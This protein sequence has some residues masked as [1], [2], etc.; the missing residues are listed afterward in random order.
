MTIMSS[1]QKDVWRACDR[2][3]FD[4]NSSPNKNGMKFQVVCD[5]SANSNENNFFNYNWIRETN[6]H[7]GS[8]NKLEE[9]FFR[10]ER[11]HLV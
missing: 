9:S 6:S 3:R 10:C 1:P 8:Q 7:G 11:E 5:K 4:K 2:K